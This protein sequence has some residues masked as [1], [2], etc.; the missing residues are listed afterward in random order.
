M[1][2]WRNCRGELTLREKEYM[3]L[4]ERNNDLEDTKE[5]GKALYVSEGRG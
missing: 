5:R 4:R 3:E 2:D 1:T